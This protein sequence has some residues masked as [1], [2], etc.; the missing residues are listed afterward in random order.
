MPGSIFSGESNWRGRW[1]MDRWDL[2]V[3]IFEESKSGSMQDSAVRHFTSHP[4]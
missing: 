4:N 1:S 2:T 3:Q